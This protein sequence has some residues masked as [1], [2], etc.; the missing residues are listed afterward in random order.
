M[1]DKKGTN[2]ES[3]PLFLVP[4]KQHYSGQ[5]RVNNVAMNTQQLFY[6]CEKLQYLQDNGMM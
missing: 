2:S 3:G 4:M 1:A 5:M 6:E